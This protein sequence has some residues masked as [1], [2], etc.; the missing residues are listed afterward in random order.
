MTAPFA[1]SFG[2]NRADVHPQVH[3]ADSF[4][5][6]QDAWLS[7]RHDRP[8]DEAPYIARAFGINGTDLPQRAQQF[9]EPCAWIALDVDR[10]DT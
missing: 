8:K 4:N 5:E 7:A 6:L 3:R 1:Y 10:F 9:A 2:R